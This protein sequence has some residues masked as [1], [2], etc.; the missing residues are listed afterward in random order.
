MN[1]EKLVDMYIQ[2]RDRRSQRKKDFEESDSSDKAYQDKIEGVLMAHFNENGV[3]R[4]GCASGTAYK[5]IRTSAVVADW[6][7]VLNFIKDKDAWEM[8]EHRV[9]KKAVEEYVSE[10]EAL[11]PGVNVTREAVVNVRRS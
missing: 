1:I 2:L 11:P 8:L 5:T 3:D 7:T 9:S 10:N 4:V 6:D